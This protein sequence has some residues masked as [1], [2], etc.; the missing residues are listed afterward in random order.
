MKYIKK[1]SAFTHANKNMRMQT[2]IIGKLR[3]FRDFSECSLVPVAVV[4]LLFYILLLAGEDVVAEGETHHG[5][6]VG[7]LVPVAELEDVVGQCL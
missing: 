4:D 7:Y 3:V 2:V 5:A 1:R 6:L